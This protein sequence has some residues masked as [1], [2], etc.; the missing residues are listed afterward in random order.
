[1]E[2]HMENLMNEENEW[3][4]EVSSSVNEGPA[5]TTPEIIC[6]LE[7]MKKHKVPGL[8]ELV[9]ERIQATGNIAVQCLTD[10]CNYGR[11]ME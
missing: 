1:M 8:S 5:D 10:L 11:P 2:K 3:D 7:K 9:S 6:A 4:H